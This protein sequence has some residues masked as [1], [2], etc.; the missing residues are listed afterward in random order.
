M[1]EWEQT[2]PVV[3]LENVHVEV[4]EILNPV[5]KDIQYV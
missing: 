5:C 2:H 4:G 3:Q 1:G